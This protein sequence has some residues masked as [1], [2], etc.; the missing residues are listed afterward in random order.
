MMHAYDNTYIEQAQIAMGTMFD[1]V[2]YDMHVDLETF[3][4]LFINTGYAKRFAMGEP[5]VVVGRSGV[6]LAYDVL[7]AAGLHPAWIQPR[8]TN[9]RSAEYWAGWALTYYVWYTTIDFDEIVR[10]I[11]L[12]ELTE[13][14]NPYHEVD[15]LQFV[16]SINALY[17]SRKAM[18]NLKFRRLT[19]GY[20]Q[21]QLAQWAD[22]P[23]RTLQQYE[24]RQKDINKAQAMTVI[25]LARILQCEPESLLEKIA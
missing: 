10:Y 5:G 16:D 12:H 1:Y 4:D 14:Y 21:S 18:T 17:L 2:V 25:K 19:C 20:T 23:L 7:Y 11:P 13:L 22:I 9:N 6:E 8:F 3:F 15:I 24:Q